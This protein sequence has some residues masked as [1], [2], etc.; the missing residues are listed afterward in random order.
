MGKNFQN[1]ETGKTGMVVVLYNP[2]FVSLHDKLEVFLKNVDVLCLVD[3][4]C[5]DSSAEFQNYTN[6][7]YKPLLG[8]H[9]IAAAQN[10]GLHALKECGVE[11][12]AFS[13]QDSAAS[14]D[15]ITFLKQ[16]FGLL[17]DKDVKVGGVGTRA[18][19][20]ETGKPYTSKSKEYE[21]FLI[22]NDG[23]TISVTRC[24]YI[25]SSISLIRL[26]TFSEIGGFD[27]S[28]FI[29]GVDNEWCWRASTKGYMF[30][31]V[32]EAKITHHLGEGDRHLAGH[33]LAISST[34]RIYYQF[35]N[36]LWLC[37]RSYV[38]GWWK[39]KHLL[40]YAAK[41]VYYPLFVS[42]RM[43]FV[44]GISRGIA[45]GLLRVAKPIFGKI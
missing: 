4:S 27:E 12:V 31:V 33:N 45:D 19:N 24:S 42:P 11:F 18:I 40:K 5:I 3:N 14:S 6:I 38:P 30:F 8:N 43:A 35:R 23:E 34:F 41:M 16:A 29:D 7:I 25:R 39:R 20:V 22:G 17:R 9:G 13:D 32:E 36:Y 10:V 37:R 2:D 1:I 21:T 15:T 44:R 28:L 26:S